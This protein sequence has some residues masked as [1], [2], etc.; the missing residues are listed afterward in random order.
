[1]DL[2]LLPVKLCGEVAS[3]SLEHRCYNGICLLAGIG[4]VL[5]TIFNVIIGID[6]LATSVTFAVGLTCLGMYARSRLRP[7]FEPL[8]RLLVAN[9][10]ALV[11]TNWFWNG[12]VSGSGIMVAMVTLVA[13]TAAQDRGLY[14]FAGLVFIPLMSLLFLLEYWAPSLVTPYAGRG[15]RFGDL[16]L[17]F[18]V[19]TLVIFFIL[20]L[21]LQAYHEERTRTAQMNQRLSR[22]LEVLNHTN[23]ALEKALAEVQT[24][25]GLLP[26]CS[27]CHK[28]RNDKGYWDGLETYIQARS[29]VRFSH[30]LCP[31]CAAQLYPDVFQPAA[32]TTGGEKKDS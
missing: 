27:A 20:W 2:R 26:L 4:C 22:N 32:P 15:A 3:Y 5:S 23:N 8:Y 18:L 25:S 29:Q 6:W 12:G 10:C 21:I 31:E 28:I 14:R 13:L 11:G 16:Y 9:G 17:T 19:A 1:M 30:S 7:A 24:L